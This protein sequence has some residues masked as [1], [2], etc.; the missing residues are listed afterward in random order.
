[1]KPVIHLIVAARPNFMKIAPLYHKLKQLNLFDIVFVHTGQ[2]YDINMSA[3]FL[4]DLSLPK[5]D[6]NLGIGS[7]T[8]AEQ[9]GY[10]MVS[11]EKVLIENPPDWIVVAGDV[12][13]T[14]ACALTAKKLNLKVAHL[15]AGLRS[16]DRTMP[17]EINR[18]VTDALADVLWTPS[19]DADVN[20]RNEG[21]E[22]SRIIR[23]GNMMIDSFEF[24]RNIIENQNIRG[25]LGLRP[26][27]YG[28]ITLH[29]PSNVDSYYTLCPIISAI[30]EL[31]EKTK[32]VFPLHPR[33]Q[34]MASKYDLLPKLQ[35]NENIV[36][37]E[38]LRYVEFMNLV[39]QSQFVITDSGGIQEET[40]YLN[41]PCMTLRKNTER[42][43][44]CSQG[45]NKLVNY[46][47]LNICYEEILKGKW[48]H[49]RKPELWDGNTAI[50]VVNS[51]ES[52][53]V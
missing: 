5:P 35:K 8:H 49:G 20:L 25:H 50:R 26:K 18:I 1:M 2:H 17:E 12:N 16:Y 32:L 47:D 41:I 31:A 53:M 44:T 9:T 10:V 28:I 29:R 30:M 27:E 36:L 19:E 52:L 37:V 39:I 46:D 11:Y 43:I 4:K 38:P 34:R 33:T 15:E 21:I 24:L 48:S 7:G 14:L 40:T 22:N 3:S 23:V 45:T 13:S 6:I 42:P 51:L